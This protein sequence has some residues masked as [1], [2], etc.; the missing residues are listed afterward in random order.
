MAKNTHRKI[1]VMGKKLQNIINMAIKGDMNVDES[2]IGDLNNVNDS[3]AILLICMKE[4]TLC[5]Y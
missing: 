1:V 5:S 4:K 3:N 2:L